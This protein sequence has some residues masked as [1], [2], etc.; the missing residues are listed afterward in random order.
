MVA[1]MKRAVPVPEIGAP[2]SNRLPL[3]S[4]AHANAATSRPGTLLGAERRVAGHCP[5]PLMLRPPSDDYSTSG[6]GSV[7]SPPDQW[8][9][10]VSDSAQGLIRAAGFHGWTR[11]RMPVWF[12]NSAD[13]VALFLW[14][15]GDHCLIVRVYCSREILATTKTHFPPLSRLL[16]GDYEMEPFW[17]SNLITRHC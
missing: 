4:P 11:A 17:H 16:R 3:F 1:A 10:S 12:L 8:Q 2:T 5:L 13:K 15:P 7:D 6:F 9:E 14:K